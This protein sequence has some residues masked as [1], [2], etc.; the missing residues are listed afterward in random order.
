MGFRTHRILLDERGRR[1]VRVLF[2]RGPN[3]KHWLAA[4]S[5]CS[6]PVHTSPA[7]RIWGSQQQRQQHE[8]TTNN[9]TPNSTTINFNTAIHQQHKRVERTDIRFTANFFPVAPAQALVS[10]PKR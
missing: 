7:P 5:L 9:N 6:Q 4:V 2:L 1:E 8:N 10:E 3:R